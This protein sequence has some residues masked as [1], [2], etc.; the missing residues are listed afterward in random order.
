GGGGTAGGS[1]YD[2]PARRSAGP[3]EHPGLH[4]PGGPGSDSRRRPRAAGHLGP[5]R[6][7]DAPALDARAEGV[8]GRQTTHAVALLGRSAGDGRMNGRVGAT[9]PRSAVVLEAN[10]MLRSARSARSSAL[11]LLLPLLFIACGPPPAAQPQSAASPAAPAAA[12]VPAAPPASAGRSDT[13]QAMGD[14]ARAEGQ[15]NLVWNPGTIGTTGDIQRFAEG[16]NKLDG[17]HISVQFTPGP[18]MPQMATR[19]IQELQA[20]RPAS[21]DVYI[22]VETHIA[23]M[24]QADALEPIDWASWAANA[25]DGR[26]LAPRGVAVQIATRVPG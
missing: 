7:P 5:G 6:D 20:G 4:R 24:M 19:T 9:R 11:G 13:L 8:R 3:T 10:S 18:S 23:A 14:A 22:G 12:S 1:A 26:L 21:T 15:L 25:R 17:L 2:G 16:L